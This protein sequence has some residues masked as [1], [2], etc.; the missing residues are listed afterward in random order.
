MG[1][2][3]L[4][5]IRDLIWSFPLLL[6]LL[7]FGGYLLIK[8]SKYPLFSC[9]LFKVTLGNLNK[10][11]LSVFSVALG[12]TMG[13]GNIIGASSCVLLFGAGSLFWIWVSAI[14][15]MIIKYSEIVLAMVYRKY[16]D[17]E[18]V[19]GPMYCMSSNF[20]SSLY[21]ILCL[22][23]SLGIGNLVPMNTLVEMVEYRFDISKVWFVVFTS[24][25]IGIVLF[26]GK[27]MI[28]NVCLYMVPIMSL[29]FIGGCLVIVCLNS[30]QLVNVFTEIFTDVFTSGSVLGGLFWSQLQ[31]GLARGI[32]SN[33]AGMGSS[34]IVHVKNKESVACVQGAWGIL[35]VGVDTLVSCTLSAL[36]VL[37]LRDKVGLDV[38]QS[39]FVCFSSV[40]GICG[41]WLYFVSM[42]FFAISGMLAWCYYAYECLKYLKWSNRW[43]PYVFI[44]IL[45][46]GSF[47]S[48]EGIWAFTDICNGL[49]LFINLTSMVGL[50]DVII[51][52]TKNYFIS[53]CY[54][55]K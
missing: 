40:F 11:G 31:M 25:V 21:A 32:Y 9:W 28:E 46:I 33:E 34:S 35:E 29:L 48:T 23:T 16:V 37:L 41:N 3:V 50:V 17:N 38:Y 10:R 55:V 30:S 15:G 22:I 19:G 26:K 8:L 6:F 12:G 52:T 20:K 2:I 39:M 24:V 54:H 44:I 42:L 14:L 49:M 27:S 51:K 7:L 4:E 47:V 53:N 45:I 1:D 43:Y 13:V 18:F 5:T 36:V